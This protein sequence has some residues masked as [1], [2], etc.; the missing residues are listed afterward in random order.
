MSLVIAIGV[1]LILFILVM[2]DL[3]SDSGVIYFSDYPISLK[4]NECDIL[5]PLIP[6]DWYDG[7]EEITITVTPDQL[8]I[9]KTRRDAPD[10][11]IEENPDSDTEL[12]YI[13]H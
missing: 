5:F 1:S 2:M 7:S 8:L 4:T 3:L 11:S 13:N 9:D 10:P 12:S 6:I